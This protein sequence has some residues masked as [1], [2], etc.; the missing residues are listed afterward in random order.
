M[1]GQHDNKPQRLQFKYQILGQ[2]FRYSHT[3]WLQLD[4]LDKGTPSDYWTFTQIFLQTHYVV[5]AIPE[6]ACFAIEVHGRKMGSKGVIPVNKCNTDITKLP[7]I[8]SLT[9]FATLVFFYTPWKYQKTYDFLMISGG[10]EKDQW[11]KM[12]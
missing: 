1:H 7:N 2:L 8:N 11:H 12:S 3:S 6:H 5:L 9:H 4:Q 10:I